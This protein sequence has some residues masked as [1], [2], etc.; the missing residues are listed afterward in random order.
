MADLVGSPWLAY[1]ILVIVTGISRM[2]CGSWFAP[3]AFVGLLWS[4]FIGASLL[5]VQYSIPGRG[6]WMLVLLIVVI[7]MGALIAHELQSPAKDSVSSDMSK[8]LN[9]LT[10]PCRRYGLLCTLIA[11]TGCVYFLI[12]SLEE[13]GLPFTFIGVLEVG[14]RWT[15]LR[16]GDAFEPWPV[17][18]LVTW[19]HP[20]GLLG[21]ILFACSNKR[22]DRVIGVITLLP[23]VMYGILT[24][25]R[26]AILLGL[27]CWI[28]GY[29]ATQCTRH[30]GRLVLFSAKR[31]TVLLLAASCIVVMFV[32]I[33]AVRDTY[34]LQSLVFETRET[35]LSNY[36]FGSPAAFANWYAHSDTSGAE[37]GARTFANEF[38]LLH[39]KTR[40]VGRYSE[41]SNELAT[42]ATNI[43]TLFR[44]FIEDFTSFGALLLTACIGGSANWIY[45]S[46]SGNPRWAIF[47]LSA[48]YSTFLFSPF[49]SF[50]SFNGTALAWLVLGFVL[51]RTNRRSAP[52]SL[53]YLSASE[54]SNP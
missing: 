1:T 3:A 50:F 51:I 31:L 49:V 22:L 15:M 47:W 52:L 8:A 21:G 17:R 45:S 43:Y 18:L 14:A 10:V 9:S 27:T 33:D 54:T 34:A 20:A 19:F 28:G 36:M 37:W 26:A 32:S 42:E 38:D 4:F 46:T 24:G 7:Q 39:L 13:F 12:I 41:M 44:G 5:M 2:R 16:L 53:P 23:A 6:L 48:F 11:V 35:H 40:I 29:V 25:A 30:P